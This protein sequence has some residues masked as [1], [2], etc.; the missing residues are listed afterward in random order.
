MSQV[1]SRVSDRKPVQRGLGFMN[2][3]MADEFYVI[4]WVFGQLFLGCVSIYQSNL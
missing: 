4:S 3:V 2:G 1:K